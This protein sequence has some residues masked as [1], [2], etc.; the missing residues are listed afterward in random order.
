MVTQAIRLPS[1]SVLPAS[2]TAL[3]AAYLFGMWL[4]ELL[5][6]A[7][8]PA[9]SIWIPTGI[10]MAVA[11]ATP[12]GRWPLW[13]GAALAAEVLGHLLWYG[14]AWGPAAVLIAANLLSAFGGA[15]L[16]RRIV[17]GQ[18]LVAAVRD[19]AVFLA[20]AVFVMPLFSATLGSMALGWS[21]DRALLAAFPRLFL[22][23]ATGTVIAAPA[24]LLLL[25]RAA[26]IP[27][28]IG[29]RPA[30][31]AVLALFFVMLAV[32][33]LGS[34]LPFVFLMLLPILWA[35]LRFRVAGAIVSSVALAFV[36]SVLTAAD[37]SPFGESAL[38]GRY[39]LQG[40]QLFLLV[41]AV[42][43]LFVGTL[44]EEV[45]Q[46]IRDLHHSNVELAE[47]NA[48]RA[49]QLAQS[50]AR[51]RETSHLLA[52]IGEAC[53]DLIFAK[54]LDL[55]LIYANGATLAAIGAELP[56]Q[57]HHPIMFVPVA[58]EEAAIRENDEHVLRTGKT[59]IAEETVTTPR[60][61]RIY[62]S[63]KAPLFN[64]EGDLAGLAGVA[65]DI[66]E[67]KAAAERERVLV[68][69]VEH[70]SRNLLAVLQSIVQL[71]RADTIPDF[72]DAIIR[73]LRA[74]ARTNGALAATWEGASFRTVLGDE[75]A[76][77][78][79]LDDVRLTLAGEDFLLDSALAQSMALI[80]H[81]LA[82]NAAKYGA[83]STPTG[84]LAVRWSTTQNAA[85]EPQVIIDWQESGGP[86]VTAPQRRGFGSTVIKAFV[87]D[88]PGGRVEHDWDSNGLHVRIIQPLLP[89][90]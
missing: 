8:G 70:R 56:P 74:L 90:S 35:A 29:W 30:E 27:R 22:G 46:A 20:V 67:S 25:G 68:R 36:A 4:T 50:E 47:R 61:P 87:E 60:G 26:P 32:V 54:N 49:V 39:G 65:V 13:A 78:L 44:T 88:R 14:H 38:Y 48:E 28:M 37:L 82:T 85:G 66:T 63:A 12:P 6:T 45:R 62:R 83:L 76:A 7:T 69:E 84:R 34:F 5:A 31:A 18:Y 89:A 59:L 23:D 57:P 86:V 77:Y 43:A 81:E 42:T 17:P 64:A 40:L 15:W 73:R 71:T 33:A 9:I 24:V 79:D 21:N 75:I 11:I 16:I 80:F 3:C 72:R 1:R 2:A 55:D 53:P 10:V 52:A 19:G 41:A 58:E 51:S